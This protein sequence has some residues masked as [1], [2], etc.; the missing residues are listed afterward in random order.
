MK[1]FKY[2]QV[3]LTIRK[4]IELGRWQVNEKLPSIRQLANQYKLANISIQHALQLLESRGLVYAKPR[5]GFYVAQSSNKPFRDLPASALEKPNPVHVPDVFFDI[6]ERSAAFDISPKAKLDV[7]ISSHLQQ[8]NRSITRSMRQ[9]Q[10]SNALYYAAPAGDQLLKEEIV[11]RYQKR[12]VNL[13]EDDVC[14]TS[15]CQNSLYLALQQVCKPG[16][17]V[18]V[19]SPAFYG[20]IQLLQHLGFHVIEIPSSYTRGMNAKALEKAA[21]QWPI[22]ACIVTPNFATPTGSNM[23]EEVMQQIIGM[24]KTYDFTLIE[25]DI[26]GDL[27]FNSPTVPLKAFDNQDNV[28][29]CSS[30]SKSLSRD[31]RLGWTI[32]KPHNKGIAQSKLISNLA[33]G[34]AIQQG[35]A[36]FIKAGHYERYLQQHRRQLLKQREQLLKAINQH[37]S[38]DVRY[39]VPDGGLSL[40]LQLPEKIDTLDLYH[41]AIKQNIVITPGCLFSAKP[42]FKSCFRLTFAH[43]TVNDRLLA[44]KQLGGIISACL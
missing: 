14:V 33:N 10:Q 36:N 19:E 43:P 17:I 38:F 29:L 42:K 25:D 28:I 3:A 34:L 12:G 27:G 20:V 30:L 8:L 5:S 24:A 41:Q 18:A 11:K 39:T 7:P 6:M 32:S 23:S 2:E 22:K 15:G 35:T 40:W 21:I 1:Q 13:Q 37:W 4:D 44:I 31:L 26:Y 16:D 9:H